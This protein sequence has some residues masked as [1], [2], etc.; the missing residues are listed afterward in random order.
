MINLTN[1]YTNYTST[2]HWTK[3][4][5]YSESKIIALAM[6]LHHEWTEN[7][8]HSKKSTEPGVQPGQN[9]W[10]FM[11]EGKLKAVD[12]VKYV[13]CKNHGCKDENGKKTGMYMPTL[14]DQTEWLDKRL[15]KSTACK[16]KKKEAQFSGKCK[17]NEATFTSGSPPRKLSLS[18]SFKSTLTTQVHMFNTEVGHII[19]GVMAKSK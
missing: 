6:T 16:D 7:K 1:L 11:H 18:K 9:P 2:G 13:F 3:D 15:A 14:H 12:G 4:D 19:A 17:S 5:K 10:N 8:N